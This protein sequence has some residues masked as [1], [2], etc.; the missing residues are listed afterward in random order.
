[1]SELTTKLHIKQN[2]TVY[3]ITVYETAEEAT[4]AGGNYL[5]V[6]NPNNNETG[7]VGLW[8]QS[9]I[10]GG[11][12]S[13]LSVTKNNIAYWLECTVSTQ[14]PQQDESNFEVLNIQRFNN[15]DTI[16]YV[17]NDSES[18]IL[19]LND[20]SFSMA[21]SYKIVY[22]N[23]NLHVPSRILNDANK[24]IIPSD[25]ELYND[26]L[27]DNYWSSYINKLDFIKSKY[28]NVQYPSNYSWLML[29][30]D[31][32]AENVASAGSNLVIDGDVYRTIHIVQGSIGSTTETYGDVTY[33]KYTV[34]NSS[35]I[36]YDVY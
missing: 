2:D 27:S 5:T 22:L 3:D 19:S 15:E 24:I 18:T 10:S 17:V 31:F 26:L 11:N 28:L 30:E 8:P 4:P 25:E 16:I 7:Y 36:I 6:F 33:K 13:P 9:E 1:M 32:T 14:Q 21:N 34:P 12:H 35:D 29:G 23:Y 20:F